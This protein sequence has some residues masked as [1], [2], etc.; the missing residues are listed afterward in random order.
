MFCAFRLVFDDTVSVRSCYHILRSRTR[1]WRYRERRVSF[2]C[3]L[4]QDMSLVVRRVSDPVFMF[5]ALGLVFGDTEG[6]RSRFHVLRARTLFRR[7]QGRQVSFLCFAP[8][9]VF[10]GTEGVSFRFHFLR[11]QTRFLRYR[12]RRIPFSCFALPYLFST[13]PRA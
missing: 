9:L 6:V 13:V 11:S 4:L 8:G 1:L 5:C 12:G 2:L 7:N 10:G 3:F